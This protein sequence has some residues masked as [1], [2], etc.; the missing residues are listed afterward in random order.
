MAALWT[1]GP[2]LSEETWAPAFL[3]GYAIAWVCYVAAA[4]LVSRARALPRRLLIWIVIAAVGMRL[5]SFA[6][7]P[8]LSTDAYRYLWDGRVA[9]A[10]IDPFSYAPEARELRPLRNENWRDISFKQ[11]PTIYPPAAQMLFAGLARVRDSDLEAFRWTFALCDIGN[12]LL[13]IALLRRTGRR[14]ERVIW[15]AWCP[16][17]ITE[18]TAGAHV[19]AFALLLFLA[20]LFFTTRVT[21]RGARLCAPTLPPAASD[22]KASVASGLALAGAVMAKGYAVLALPLFIRR[23]GWRFAASFVVAGA[24]LLLPYARA[25]GHLFAGLW[26]YVG[27][28]ETNASVFLVLDRLLARVTEDHFP[29]TRALTGGAVVLVVA[30]LTWRLKPEPPGRPRRLE[31]LLRASFLAFGA[32]LLL[33]APTLPW[34]VIWAVPALCWWGVPGLALFTLTVSA[35]YYGRWLYPGDRAAHYALLWY[36]YLPVYALLIGQCL[37]WAAVGRRSAPGRSA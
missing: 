25:G 22:G 8:L 7:T 4:A 1:T 3:R 28:W 32:Q 23:A 27:T 29:I 36:G 24:L 11:V 34:Y 19:D 30:V 31:S 26:A 12:V 2:A 6:R 18:A 13:L 10:G 35:Q 16:L 33:G 17:A 37:W 9:N 14:P 21:C 5:V 15:Y 20:A